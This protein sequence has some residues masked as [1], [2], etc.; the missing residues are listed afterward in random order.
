MGVNQ[1]GWERKNGGRR[2]D[3]PEEA[4]P[5]I[6]YEDRLEF[7]ESPGVEDGHFPRVSSCDDGSPTATTRC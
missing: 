7:K 2:V 4:G 3:H 5:P 1:G 6:E